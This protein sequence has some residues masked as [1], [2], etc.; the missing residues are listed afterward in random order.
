[1]EFI[2]LPIVLTVIFLFC[3]VFGSFAN[4]VIY[5]LHTG[6]SLNNRSHCLSCG[7]TLTWYEL[8]PLL[9]YVLLRGRCRTCGSWIPFRYLAVELALGLVFVLTYLHTDSVVMFVLYASFMFALLVGAV[10]DLYHLIIPDEIVIGAVAAA[11]LARGYEAVVTGS[12]EGFISGALGAVAAFGFLG[13]LWLIS[14]GRWIGFGDAKLAIPLAF[15]V[16]L[17]GTFS[18][19]VLSFW[20]GAFV[21][22]SVLAYQHL[23]VF[24]THFVTYRRIKASYATRDVA[25]TRR[26]F[27]MKS[28][29]PFAPFLIVAFALVFFFNIDVLTFSTYLLTLQF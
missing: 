15:V 5:R 29:I 9:S 16:G 18:L 3:V 12:L 23:S 20:V 17:W 4:V 21:S 13:G 11:V 25:K 14:R 2:P 7:E 6:R 24:I 26:Y 1:M 28:E 10:Y 8:I 27:T 22:V 19:I